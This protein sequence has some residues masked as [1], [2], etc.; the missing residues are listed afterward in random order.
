MV[1]RSD[2]RNQYMQQPQQLRGLLRMATAAHVLHRRPHF[3]Y[4][5]IGIECALDDAAAAVPGHGTTA[6]SI[7]WTKFLV[8]QHLEEQKTIFDELNAIFGKSNRLPD[9]N[10]LAEIEYFEC[11]IKESHAF[12]STC[13]THIQMSSER[14]ENR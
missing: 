11:V 10:D 12:V 9:Q 2:H 5:S 7:A 8:G 14:C 4:Q 13:C 1:R 3:T 6:T